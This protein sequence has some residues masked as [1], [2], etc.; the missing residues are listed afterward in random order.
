MAD[1]QLRD[2]PIKTLV[3]VGP[4][5]SGKSALA[6]DLAQRLNGVIINLDAMQVYREL[7]IMTAR[8]SDADL[9][10]VP[11]CLY[12][13]QPAAEP[14]SAAL[15]Q[16]QAITAITETAAAGQLPILCGGTGFYLK[17]LLEG[18]SPI[19]EIPAAIRTQIRADHA[20]LGG[21][22][23]RQQLAALDPITAAR[24]H[25]GDQQ[26]L[27]RA[28]EVAVATSTPLSQWHQGGNVGAADIEPLIFVLSPPREILY[29]RCDERFIAMIEAGAVAE[30]AQLNSLKLAADL[31]AMKAVGVPQLID[32]INKTTTIDLATEIAQ[33]NTRRYAKRQLTWFTNQI[34]QFH[35]IKTQYSENIFN[36]IFP[37]IRQFLLTAPD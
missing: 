32:Y 4:T 31:P 11:H 23:F 35:P 28:M 17:A 3:I 30:V 6:V 27:I 25:D 2:P 34:K 29:Q 18:L 26:R 36:D 12:G 9:A 15:W 19:P 1:Q 33:R 24:L 14:Y 7:K 37:K 5:A 13:F 22:A 20:D 21:P 16:A 10:R 8:P